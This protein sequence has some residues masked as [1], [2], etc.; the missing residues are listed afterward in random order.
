MKSKLIV[1][2]CLIIL[3]NALAACSTGTVGTL[4][5]EDKRIPLRE[6]QDESGVWK[7]LEYAMIYHYRLDRQNPQ[8]PGKIAIS[9]DIER[10]GVS[11]DSLSIWINFLDATGRILDRKSVFMSGFRSSEVDPSFKVEMDTPSGATAM[12]FSHVSQEQR[13]RNR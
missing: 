3:L 11:L 1:S 9:G 12:S 5:P 6:G 4:V 10:G 7:T 8:T 13:G 2:T